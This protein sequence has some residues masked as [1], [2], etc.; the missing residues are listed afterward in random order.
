MA[1]GRSDIVNA[2]SALFMEYGLRG[3]TMR[4]LAG[5]LGVTAPAIYRHF[6]SK[7]AV[8]VGVLKEAYDLEARYLYRALV[9]STPIERFG[10]AGQAYVDFALENSELY[11]AMH[12]AKSL[13]TGDG[14]P[15]EVR[16]LGS[17]IGQFWH[18][19][20][21]ECLEEGF[22]KEGNPVEIGTTMW[23]HAHGLLSIY[24]HGL[25]EL[26]EEEFR[27][28]FRLSGWRMMEGIGTQKMKDAFLE[29]ECQGIRC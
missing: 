5:A 24:L 13:L 11:L 12:S 9:G 29:K 27:E 7:D 21:R 15:E 3:W 17:A 6:P 1:I 28:V 10:L 19:R 23:A 2:A 26:N 20:V 22:L 16:Q 8:V 4:G 14:I 18:D 25:T